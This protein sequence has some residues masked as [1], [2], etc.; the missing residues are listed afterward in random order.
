MVR[1]VTTSN[2]RE[3]MQAHQ[4][5]HQPTHIHYG[6]RWGILAIVALLQLS[7]AMQWV[8]YAPVA[9]LAAGEST[10][11]FPLTTAQDQM[12]VC[13]CVC[14]CVWCNFRLISFIAWVRAKMVYVR[15]G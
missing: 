3:C 10:L 11:Q 13:V 7:N 1:V 6:R 14:V 2:T 12:C 4:P 5:G 15:F 9:Q 8:N